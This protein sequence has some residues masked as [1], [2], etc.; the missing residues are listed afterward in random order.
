MICKSNRN[1]NDP[2][3]P[4][5]ENPGEKTSMYLLNGS[6]EAVRNQ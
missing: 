2:D 3:E 6:E 1:Q 4:Q 5:I